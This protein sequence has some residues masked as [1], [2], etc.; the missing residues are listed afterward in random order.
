MKVLLIATNR[1][2]RYMNRMEA[3][4]LPIGLAY[5]AGH[6]DPDQ[7]RTKL[8]DLMFSDDYLADVATAIKD[9]QPDV[10]GLSIRNLDNCS[11][12]NSKTYYPE[13]RKIVSIVQEKTDVPVLVGGG[14]V[15]VLPEEL[16]DYLGVSYAAVGEGEKIVKAY[17]PKPRIF[18][19]AFHFIE[20]RPMNTIIQFHTGD[21]ELGHR[22]HQL[23]SGFDPGGFP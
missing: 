18:Q 19:R 21:I 6:L 10:V 20:N 13:T 11:Y 23:P 16:A 1:H 17:D 2:G 9:F 5:V 7:H 22:L 15:S 3:Q 8:L 14:A 4:P 12:S